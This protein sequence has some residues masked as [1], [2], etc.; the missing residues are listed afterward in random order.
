M[1]LG[2]EGEECFVDGGAATRG[3]ACGQWLYS[4][5]PRSRAENVRGAGSIREPAITA[6]RAAVRLRGGKAGAFIRRV[7]LGLQPNHMPGAPS[8]VGQ[9]ANL[10]VMA[11]IMTMATRNGSSLVMRQNRSERCRRPTARALRARP[12]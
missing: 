9:Y 1:L 5:A 11:R 7:G 6:T 2:R 8:S 12:R 4:V 3:P 10:V